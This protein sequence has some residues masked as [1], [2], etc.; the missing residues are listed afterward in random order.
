MPNLVGRYAIRERIGQGAMADV[1]RAYDPNIQRELAIK[2]LRGELRQN[3]EYASRFLREAKAAGALGHPNIVTVY[4]VGEVDGFPYI[5][6]ELLDG[7]PLDKAMR[8][9]QAFEPAR[10]IDIGLQLA[11]ALR[12]AHA[13][14]VVHRDIKPSNIHLSADGRAVKL[15]DFGIARVAEAMGDG[16]M[17]KTQAGQVM[18]TPRYMSP[19]QALCGEVDGRSDLFSVGVILY[20]LATGKKAFAGASAATLALQITQGEP[21]PLAQAAPDTPRGL[22]FIISKLMAKRPERRFA[23]GAQLAEALRREAAVQEALAAERA[24]PR[25]LLSLSTKLALGA[26]TAIGLVLAV[27]MSVVLNRQDAAMERMALTSGAAVSSFVA[28]NAALRAADNATLPEGERDWLPVQAFVTAASADP[29]VRDMQVVDAEGVI[30]GST[31]EHRVGHAYRAPFGER[32]VRRDG[33]LTVTALT[34]AHDGFRFTRPILYAGRSFGRVDVSLN[35]TELSN[36]STLS[37]LLMAVLGAAVLLATG[38]VSF[39]TARSLTRPMRR[40]RTAL[41]DAAGGNMEFRISHHRKDEIGRLFDA[42]NLLAAS[43]GER[44]DH[45]Q[46]SLERTQV[47][48]PPRPAAPRPAPATGPAVESPFAAPA[49]RGAKAPVS[50]G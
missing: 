33:P 46:A 32:V 50:A 7:Q 14:G 31:D 42:F 44:M 45:A 27:G 28:S 11:E 17:L 9:G 24:G 41:T 21:E 8:P 48:T 47:L 1:Y 22:Q 18:G 5:A 16:E 26:V 39:A 37:H 25:R 10:V 23:D 34:G 35:R 12:Y 2:V 15:L 19:E 13:Q 30:R 20:E 40:L 29:N 3:R 36:A 43:A 6:M 4:D 49:G 38:L